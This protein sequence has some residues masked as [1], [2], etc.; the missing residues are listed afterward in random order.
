MT[1]GHE[2]DREVL[3]EK[4][5][6]QVV[7]LEVTMLVG[8]HQRP[9]WRRM[10][11][12]GDLYHLECIRPRAEDGV[13]WIFPLVIVTSIRRCAFRRMTGVELARVCDPSLSVLPRRASNP[14]QRADMRSGPPPLY[15][16]LSIDRMDWA[17]YLPILGL[18]TLPECLTGPDQ[19]YLEI[20]G[21][22]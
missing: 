11:R 21:Q 18:M 15:G 6:L 16:N 1:L 9:A 10:S 12:K 20:L 17:A 13:L 2:Q 19:A 3:S 14:K 22:A 8:Q 7:L 5:T 4:I